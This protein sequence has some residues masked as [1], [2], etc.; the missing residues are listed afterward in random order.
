M[1]SLYGGGASIRNLD[2]GQ[3]CRRQIGARGKTGADFSS[4]RR[5]ASGNP[6]ETL[7][8]HAAVERQPHHHNRSGAESRENPHRAAAVK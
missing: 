8:R 1:P 3:G 6:F 2:A 5:H 4:F 7:L